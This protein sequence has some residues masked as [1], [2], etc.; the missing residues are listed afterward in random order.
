M[1]RSSYVTANG[2]TIL[3]ASI[4]EPTAIGISTAKEVLG[5]PPTASI[6]KVSQ[7]GNKAGLS[8]RRSYA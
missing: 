4:L 5:R 2:Y 6:K 7:A 3:M 8:P 1:P